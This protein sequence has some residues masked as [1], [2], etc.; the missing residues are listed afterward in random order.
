M[1]NKHIYKD[2]WINA[3]P[4]VIWLSMEPF[5]GL[6]DV[7]IAGN[8]SLD[9]L[10]AVGIG[11]TIYFVTT[12]LFIFLAYGTTP[13][14]ADL[15]INN[16]FESLR[17]FIFYGRKISIYLGA[18]VFLI[19]LVFENQFINLFKPTTEVSELSSIYLISRSIGIPFFLLNMHS[20]AVLRGLRF[21]KYT[22]ISSFIS[23]FLNILLSFTLGIIAGFGIMGIGIAS[24]IS[25]FVA[26]IYSTYVL[27]FK[28][29]QHLKTNENIDKEFIR[30]K[31]FNVGSKIFIRSIFLTAFMATLSN[32]ASRLSMNDIALH[33][34][35][36]QMWNIS[37]TFVDALAIAA[38]TLVAEHV[39][40]NKRFIKSDLRK[41]FIRLTFS[42]SIF[43]S[44]VFYFGIVFFS[45]FVSNQTF[46]Q[47]EDIRIVLVFCSTIFFGYFAFLW[48]GVLLGLDKSKEFSLIT[49]FGSIAGFTS[50][51]FLLNYQQSLL[52]IWIALAISLIVRGAMGAYY[53]LD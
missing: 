53:Q 18:F 8:L 51:F 12:W 34:V 20:T 11:T 5:A 33:H 25:F 21:P 30:K 16:K 10:S 40:K 17:F 7:S 32:Q 49:I 28:I 13:Y 9:S 1:K 6:V 46:I 22:T 50:L 15:K 23:T 37:Y 47:F 35:L 2:I 29:K 26:S 48:D 44:I 27:N 3:Y 19:I 42:V 38:Q 4:I 52:F 31:F 39:A 14:V 24:S 45:E 43:L 36:Q 41:S